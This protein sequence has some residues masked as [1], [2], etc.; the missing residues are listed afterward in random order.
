[1]P[2]TNFDKESIKQ[3]IVGKLMRYNGITVAEATSLQLYKAVATTVRDQIMQKWYASR[4]RSKNAREKKLY[5][6]SVEFLTGRS[7]N[8]N[9]INLCME[10]TYQQALTELGIDLQTI[11]PEEPE[12]A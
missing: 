9:L 3:S 11:L 5:Y 10:D 4:E 8:C 6:L 7:L 12:P 1:M 2:V